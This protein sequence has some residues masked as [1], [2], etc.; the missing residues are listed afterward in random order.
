MILKSNLRLLLVTGLVAL[1]STA[2]SQEASLK[3]QAQALSV[4]QSLYE[5][6]TQEAKKAE[7]HEDYARAELLYLD[8]ASE[9]EKLGA[10]N[11]AL[12]TSLSNLA[13]FYWAQGDGD[14]ADQ[15]FRRALTMKEKILGLEH[16]DLASDLFGLGAV[17]A[18]Q[19]KYIEAGALYKR[20]MNIL[21][22]AHL[23][24][25]AEAMKGYAEVLRKTNQKEA[26]EKLE[27]RNKV[28]EA[29]R[30]QI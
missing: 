30:A 17:R 28:S 25:P 10:G 5:Q 24:I 21:Q 9:A 6:C 12:A 19:G 15:M 2:C 29:K 27:S 16:S 4:Q 13:N 3:D 8:A 22:T 26:A 7:E 11:A 1:F 23:P 14:R 18:A 20:G